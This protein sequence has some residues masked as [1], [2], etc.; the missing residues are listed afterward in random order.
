MLKK[1]IIATVL[2]ND[3]QVI[4]GQQFDSWRSVGHVRQAIK[5]YNSREVDEVILLD[6]TA[7][8]EN[9]E[10]NFDL[11]R[12]LASEFFSPI[13]IG[14]GIRTVE[15][16]RLALANGADKVCI[17]TSALDNPD[18]IVEAAEK[19]GS[20]AV[21]VCIDYRSV[22]NS[23]YCEVRSHSGRSRV[24]GLRPKRWAKTVEY[25][26]AGEIVLNAIDRDGM[27]EGYDLD[28]IAEISSVVNIPV[29]AC[30]GCGSYEHMAQAFDAGASAVASGAVWLWEDATPAEAA[31]YLHERGYPVRRHRQ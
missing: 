5:V 18:L 27:M 21:T 6:I 4:K 1:R 23:G 20:Q 22:A 16:F 14:G 15:H 13:T 3:E 17:C 26:G 29:V 8:N 2:Y 28:T 19:F 12:D 10:P 25:F 11:I 9:R 24:E 30:G 31:E 7:T